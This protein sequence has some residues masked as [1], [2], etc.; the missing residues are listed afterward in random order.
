MVGLNIEF[1]EMKSR[2]IGRQPL[3]PLN[4]VFTKIKKE[5]SRRIVKLEKRNSEFTPVEK[6]A[7]IASQELSAYKS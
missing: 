6:S 4:E 5:E 1:D 3:P 2:V 7:L